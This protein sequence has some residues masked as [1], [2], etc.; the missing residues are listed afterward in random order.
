MSRDTADENETGTF[1]DTNFMSMVLIDDVWHIVRPGWQN[2][3]AANGKTVSAIEPT[4]LV[5]T[6]QDMDNNEEEKE[7]EPVEDEPV[8]PE[9]QSFMSWEATIVSGLPELLD[10]NGKPPVFLFADPKFIGKHWILDD[11]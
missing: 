3:L 6:P 1:I 2:E 5:S 8:E 9:T 7:D 10:E 4:N 11:E